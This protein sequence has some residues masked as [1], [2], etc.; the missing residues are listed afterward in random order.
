[1]ATGQSRILICSGQDAADGIS[2]L[3][4]AWDT[5]M[6]SGARVAIKANFNSADPFPAGTDPETLRGIF[7]ALADSGAK[8]MTLAERSGM[9]DTRTVLKSRGIFTCAEEFGCTVKIID[10]FG[11]AEF[12]RILDPR[13]HWRQGFLIARD[14]IEA[15]R[16]VSTCCLKTHRFGGYFTLS[17]KNSVGMIAKRDPKDA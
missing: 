11:T 13:Y 12:V 14:F 9:G 10:S 7:S 5:R 4:S 8:S 6:F 16:I 2:R 15:D 1:M 17:L 3:L